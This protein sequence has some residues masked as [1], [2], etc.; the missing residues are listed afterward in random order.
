MAPIQDEIRPS[1]SFS[2][3]SSTSSSSTT[4]SCKSV[5]FSRFIKISFTYPGDEYD[6]SAL[7]PAKLT[8]SE[9]SELLELRCHWRKEMSERIIAQELQQQR[10]QQQQALEDDSDYSDVDEPHSNNNTCFC[11]NE[12][13]YSDKS[14][15]EDNNNNKNTILQ[16]TKYISEA[17][18][19]MSAPSP[20][21]QRLGR[22]QQQHHHHHR[23]CN[24]HS[25]LHHRT[26]TSSSSGIVFTS[27]PCSP[28]LSPQ[29][30]CSNSSSED[31][32]DPT[33]PQHPLSLSSSQQQLQQQQQQQQAHRLKRFGGSRDG[34][35]HRHSH[36][37]QSKV[38]VQCIAI[39]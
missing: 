35:M 30:S 1:S 34:L 20:Q 33:L 32:Y 10:Q 9:A 36:L 21:Q 16:N 14:D 27:P 2:S 19:P 3:T 22:R 39:A 31:E 11:Q 15:S 12:S 8:F 7:E 28:L 13:D 5:Q 37:D 29:D 17:N 38:N 23:N 24:P 25:L 4:S 6:R 26:K 18:T